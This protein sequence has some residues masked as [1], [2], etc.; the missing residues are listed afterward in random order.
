R[1]VACLGRSGRRCRRAAQSVGPAGFPRFSPQGERRKNSLALLGQ[2]VFAD[3]PRP[4]AKKRG[5]LN[6]A[7][8][9]HRLPLLGFWLAVRVWL[10]NV[11]AFAGVAAKAVAGIQ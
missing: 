7:A 5:D 8:R 9:W 2:T 4:E 6:G 1:R 10:A 11:R 3:F